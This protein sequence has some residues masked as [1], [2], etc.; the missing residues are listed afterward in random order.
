M[1]EFILKDMVGRA[2]MAENF[3]IASAATSS[4]E[5]G[6]PV[7]PP[8]RAVLKEHGIDCSGYAA[9]RMRYD[10]YEAY[11]MII[12]M[13][14]EN[15]YYMKRM[16]PEDPEGK[17]S[18]LMDHT[19]DPREVSDPWYTRDFDKAYSDILEGCESLLS[20]L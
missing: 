5:L 20:I 12:G 14:S 8:A 11:D 3:E 17:L 4:E 2:G 19:K 15:M 16:W 6:N 10:D 9:R 18:L 13:D 1:G 7:Y